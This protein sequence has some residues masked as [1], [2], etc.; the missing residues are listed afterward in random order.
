[1]GHF[2]HSR[3]GLMGTFALILGLIGAC[4]AEDSLHPVGQRESLRA[5]EPS[6]P[7]VGKRGMLRFNLQFSN[8][9]AVDL[10]L[11]VSEPNG[12]TLFYAEPNSSSGGELDVDCRCGSCDDGPNEN[13]TWPGK[14]P[15]EGN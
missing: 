1:M 12:T 7:L 11:Y 3:L 10:D 5:T 14:E 15:P 6:R 9:E 2:C 4:G 13:I 8:H